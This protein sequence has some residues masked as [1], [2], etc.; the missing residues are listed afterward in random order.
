MSQYEHNFKK[1]FGQNFIQDIPT[2]I[3][4]IDL[5]H[6][7]EGE[8]ILEIGPGDGKFTEAILH[9]TSNIDLVEI[10][11]ELIYFLTEKFKDFESVK[12]FNEDIL[13]FDLDNYKNTKFKVFGALPYNISK[14]IIAKFIENEVKPK[15]MVF[16]T[17]KEVAKDYCAKPPKATFLSNYANLF[18]DVVYKG[19]IDRSLFYPKPKVDGGILYLKPNAKFKTQRSTTLISFVKNGFRNPRKKLTNSLKSIYKTIDWEKELKDIGINSNV[20]AAELSLE[21]WMSLFMKSNEKQKT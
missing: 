12:I 17:Q 18:C 8:K 1:N 13:K 10:D 20:R 21:Q 15:L 9:K 2:I 19:T 11:K 5:L 3:S 6:L 4:T 16:I 7:E 14:P